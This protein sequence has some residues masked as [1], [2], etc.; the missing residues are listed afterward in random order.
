MR[1]VARIWA[2]FFAA[3]AWSGLQDSASAQTADSSFFQG[4][5]VKIVVGYSPGGGYDVYAHMIA[6]YLAKSLGATVIVDNEPGAGGLRAIDDLYVAPDD[7]LTIMLAKGN[8]ALMA[9]LTRQPG[10]R[11]DLAKFA[12]LGG[13]GVSPELWVAAPGSQIQS[14]S[15]ALKSTAVIRWSATGPMDGASDV[16]AMICEALKLHCRVILGYT[17]TNDMALA[18]GRNEV[19]ATV[20]SDAS[21][22]AYVKEKNA[23]PVTTLSHARSRYFPNLPTIYEATSLSPDA[24]FWFDLRSTTAILGRIFIAPPGV[25]PSRLAVLQTAVRKALTDPALVAQGVKM[26]YYVEYQPPESTKAA[27]RKILVQTSAADQQRIDKVVT[28]K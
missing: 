24:K 25:S 7:G 13:T 17:G 6:P 15:D 26:Q 11:Y 10:V 12:Y 16:S 5:T 27:A 21:A 22:G 14:V 8:A 2:L 1:P 9:Q 28:M 3:L 23:R 20:L 19:D 4:K 18:L